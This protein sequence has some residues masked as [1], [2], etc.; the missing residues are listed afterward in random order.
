MK[1]H[2][3]A[4]QKTAIVTTTSN[5][6]V[7]HTEKRDQT[8]AAVET[9]LRVALDFVAAHALL[10]SLPRGWKLGKPIL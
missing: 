10:A 1:P 4:G 3:A 7:S 2:R 6:A 8:V 9:P 5:M